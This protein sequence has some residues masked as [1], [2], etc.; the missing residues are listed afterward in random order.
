[1][2][3]RSFSGWLQEILGYDRFFIWVVL[4][5]IPSFLVAA[6]VRFPADFGRKRRGDDV[7]VAETEG[8]AVEA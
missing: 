7:R 6:L 8:A 3:F 2:L 4:A 1:M 5:T